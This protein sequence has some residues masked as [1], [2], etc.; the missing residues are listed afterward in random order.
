[1]IMDWLGRNGFGA[2]VTCPCGC[3]P[4]GVPGEYFHK[5][6][7]GTGPVTKAARF[8]RPLVAVMKKEVPLYEG[9]SYT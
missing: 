2:T 6:K 4:G 7:T 3:L 9:T 5:K 8:L 1:M